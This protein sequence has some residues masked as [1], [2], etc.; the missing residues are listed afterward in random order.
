M[1][2]LGA[3]GTSMLAL[4]AIASVVPSIAGGFTLAMTLPWLIDIGSN[5]LA[6]WRTTWAE[7]AG[8]KAICG[9]ADDEGALLAK[10]AGDLQSHIAADSAF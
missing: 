6:T 3:A 9:R 10:I 1:P 5:A 8:I 2:L 4:L 7:R